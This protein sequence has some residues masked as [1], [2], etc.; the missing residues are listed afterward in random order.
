MQVGLASVVCSDYNISV[1]SYF[2]CAQA[3]VLWR[4][5]GQSDGGTG[6]NEPL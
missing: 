5:E 1:N 3:A 4:V 6:D 2:K